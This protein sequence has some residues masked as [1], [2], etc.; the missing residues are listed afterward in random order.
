M[1][2]TGH[3]LHHHAHLSHCHRQQE[4]AAAAAA[5]RLPADQEEPSGSG[6]TYRQ[7]PQLQEQELQVLLQH[8]LRQL[9]PGAGCGS[10]AAGCGGAHAAAAAA[11]GQGRI[12]L[13]NPAILLELLRHSGMCKVPEDGCALGW[14]CTWVK[15]LWIH[16]HTCRSVSCASL[17]CRLGKQVLPHYKECSDLGCPTCSRVRSYDQALEELRAL[18]ARAREVSMAGGESVDS[19]GGSQGTNDTTPSSIFIAGEKQQQH[20]HHCQRGGRAPAAAAAAAGCGG[21][22]GCA[23]GMAISHSPA[24]SVTSKPARVAR[25]C[26]EEEEVE[27]EVYRQQ[28]FFPESW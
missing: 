15:R 2:T 7:Q 5:Q 25:V 6:P 8:Q 11:G 13:H 19:P 23:V 4:E 28:R 21:A 27:Q 12:D 18:T 16:M 14:R 3:S 20:M 22:G 24:L 9:V 1:V 26:E 17:H 10:A